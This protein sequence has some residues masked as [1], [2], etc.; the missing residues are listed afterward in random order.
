MIIKRKI[1]EYR[2][3]MVLDEIKSKEAI[4]GKLRGD[5]LKVQAAKNKYTSQKAYESDIKSLEKEASKLQKKVDS[6]KTKIEK[7]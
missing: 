1:Q 7:L 5:V 6:L 3:K 4:I 2:D